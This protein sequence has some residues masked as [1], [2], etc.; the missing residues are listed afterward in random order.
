MNK[1]FSF[2]TIAVVVFFV[3]CATTKRAPVPFSFVETG[4]DSASI[5]IVGGNPGV[6][7]V[8]F[9]KNELPPPAENTYW[10]PLSFPAGRPL[11][12]TVHASYQQQTNSSS[13]GGFLATLIADVA[14]SAIAASRTVERDVLFE[15]PALETDKT[16]KL[17]FRKGAGV[18][19]KNMLVLSDIST[20][21]VVY[22]QEF[23]SK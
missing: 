23:E 3:G 19:G 11:Q 16:Y 5:N 6:W 22:E 17:V 10:S 20:G 13:S 12:I 1:V 18:R 2:L 21:K 15:C 14:S 8:Y 7:L 4:E 9:D